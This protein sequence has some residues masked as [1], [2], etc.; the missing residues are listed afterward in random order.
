LQRLA[1]GFFGTFAEHRGAGAGS[2]ATNT[3]EFVQRTDSVALKAATRQP[4]SH[5]AANT[6]QSVNR[7]VRHAER[8]SRGEVRVPSLFA[9]VLKNVRRTKSRA[10]RERAAGSTYRGTA[11]NTGKVR[12]ALNGQRTNVL[13]GVAY[14]LHVAET[15]RGAGI[16]V[17]PLGFKSAE[18]LVFAPKVAYW[19]SYRLTNP[20]QPALQSINS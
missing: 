10:N 16:L 7:A 17:K 18:V 19:K 12:G 11:K 9:L 13:S 8:Q 5:R 3:V 1:N 4:T 15:A 20:V 6:G 2:H 14:A